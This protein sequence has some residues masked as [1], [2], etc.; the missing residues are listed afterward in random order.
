MRICLLGREGGRDQGFAGCTVF[1]GIEGAR[2]DWFRLDKHGVVAGDL[3]VR[4]L[5]L[6]VGFLF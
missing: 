3:V 4:N 1:L 5:G 6:L 2:A